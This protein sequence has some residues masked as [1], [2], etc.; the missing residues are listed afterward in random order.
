[1]VADYDRQINDIFVVEDGNAS[2]A[3]EALRLKLLG[4]NGQP[5][6]PNL[7]SANP[8]LGTRSL[9]EEQPSLQKR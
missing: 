2:A 4:G 9:H 5:V 3:T 6:A 1:L 7:R 8:E